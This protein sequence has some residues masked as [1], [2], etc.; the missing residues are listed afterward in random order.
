MELQNISNFRGHSSKIISVSCSKEYSFVIT[1]DNSGAIIIWDLNRKQY[2]KTVEFESNIITTQI[3]GN[4]GD[5]LACSNTSLG[6]WDIN[7]TSLARV[8]VSKQPFMM[9]QNG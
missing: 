8:V 2:V 3:N 4:T 7:G 9:D 6:L 1:G 5:F